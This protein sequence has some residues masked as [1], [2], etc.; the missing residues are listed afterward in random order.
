MAR[1]KTKGRLVVSRKTIHYTYEEMVKVALNNPDFASL[2]YS[3]IKEIIKKTR[4]R[5][6]K[7]LKMLFCNKCGS[8]LPFENRRIRCGQIIIHCQCGHLIRSPIFV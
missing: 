1:K 7:S 6:S 4:V 5:P 8:L 3:E 2:L